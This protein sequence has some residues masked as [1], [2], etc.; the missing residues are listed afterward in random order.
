M[1]VICELLGVPPEDEP[2]FR[3]W[4]TTSCARRAPQDQ[5][6]ADELLSSRTTTGQQLGA[7]LFELIGRHR[8]NPADNL[9]SRL[10]NDTSTDRWR[11]SIWSPR[12]G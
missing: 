7:Y 8:A 4:P 12:A 1:A 6:D 5:A 3:A 11:T 10:A 2:T 9:L